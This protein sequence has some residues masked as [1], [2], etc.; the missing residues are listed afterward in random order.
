MKFKPLV[1]I[2]AFIAGHLV[3]KYFIDDEAISFVVPPIVAALLICLLIA[4]IIATVW[5][6]IDGKWTE[7]QK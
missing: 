1:F 6:A 5:C 4:A 7:E 3:T 2:P